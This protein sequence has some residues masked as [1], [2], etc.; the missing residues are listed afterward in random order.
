MRVV[1][2]EC[3]LLGGVGTALGAFLGWIEN[4]LLHRFPID[5]S[6]SLSDASVGGFY[7]DPAMQMDISTFHF[8]FTLVAVYAMILVV[9]IYPAWRAGNLEPVEAL[10]SL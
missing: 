8:V 9:G 3:A 6:A 1:L 2:V 7:L 4:A 5:L 10:H